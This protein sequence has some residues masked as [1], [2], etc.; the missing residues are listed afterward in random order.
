MDCPQGYVTRVRRLNQMLYPTNSINFINRLRPLMEVAY[1]GKLIMEQ[2]WTTIE[3]T[4]IPL[5]SSFGAPIILPPN[6]EK[7][8]VD[9]PRK[10]ANIVEK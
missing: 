7:Y 6:Y 10:K 4:R 3:S 8:S 2:T 1:I 5:S 9:S